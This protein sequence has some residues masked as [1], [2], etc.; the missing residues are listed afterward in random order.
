MTRSNSSGSRSRRTG[1]RWSSGSLARPGEDDRIRPADAG[2]ACGGA[3][4]WRALMRT[5]RAAADGVTRSGRA[6]GTPGLAPCRRKP[7]PP[8]CCGVRRC[9]LLAH[10]ADVEIDSPVHDDPLRAPVQ[11]ASFSRIVAG[12]RVVVRVALRA[13]AMLGHATCD[14]PHIPTRG[15][16]CASDNFLVVFEGA[17]VVGYNPRRRSAAC[18]RLRQNRRTVDHRTRIGAHFGLVES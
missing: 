13:N 5:R 6:P 4:S 8:E 3:L 16:A 14:Q 2:D 1:R 11:C 15:R 9:L 7:K 10:L 12:H 17:D 18:C